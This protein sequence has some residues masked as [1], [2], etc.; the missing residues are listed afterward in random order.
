MPSP[1]DLDRRL[2]SAAGSPDTE[3][4]LGDVMARIRRRTRQRVLAI[5]TVLAVAGGLVALS[6]VERHRND[7]SSVFVGEPPGT[8]APESTSGETGLRRLWSAPDVGM[9]ESFGATSGRLA[10]AWGD[11]IFAAEGFGSGGGDA[12][13]RISGLERAS[14]EVRWTARLGG[15]AFLQGATGGVVIANTQYEKIVGL[16]ADDG[17]VRWEISL[18][19][20]GLDG[21]GA[22]TS[23]IAE[24]LSAIGLSANGEGD[25][26]PPV[27]L[28]VNTSTGAVT[29]RTPLVEGTDLEWGTPPVNDG[30]TVF[31]STLSHA[32]SARENVAH[33]LDVADGSVRWMAGTG[34]GQ[35]FHFFPAVIN[36][37][38]VHLPG[39]PELVTVDRA[40]GSRRWSR[41]G[42]VGALVGDRLWVAGSGGSLAEVDPGT[43]DVVREIASP[44]EYPALLLE[45]GE[46]RL[47]LLDLEQLAVLDADG[48]VR[49]RQAWQASLVDTPHV[50]GNMLFVSTG[51]QALT[52]Y[53]IP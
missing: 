34:G 48:Q 30:Q 4:A 28:G 13:G 47:G 10:V 45:L 24:P 8:S 21:Y 20:L 2:R 26:R 43:G 25:V 16:D 29:W 12:V 31:L 15:P 33:L 40:D 14:G 42:P 44:I 51:D 11:G 18:S 35:S 52:A 17:T 32:G 1:L 39:Y 50:D 3:K 38:Y 53:S 9:G 6:L 49:L 46:G 19:A 37:P 27:V 7:D 36:G 22:V 41:P 23:A 5:A